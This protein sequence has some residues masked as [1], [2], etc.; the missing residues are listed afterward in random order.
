MRGGD[1]KEAET[2]YRQALALDSRL[3]A[4]WANIGLLQANARRYPEAAKSFAKAHALEPKNPVYILPL[5]QA[6]SQAGQLTGA[7]KTLLEARR[8]WPREE[9]LLSLLATVQMSLER[10][11]AAA[12]TLKQLNA[13]RR[14]NDRQTLGLL[15]TALLAAGRRKEARPYARQMAARFPKD[16]TAHLLV[17]DI[18]AQLQD[19]RE[20]TKAYSRAFTLNP[21]A[22]KAALA[23]GACAE[24][25]GDLALAE[26]LYKRLAQKRFGEPVAR[27]AQ[28]KILLLKKDYV[29][30]QAQL[31]AAFL[32][33]K[34]AGSEPEFLV[35]LGEALLF[36]GRQ[37]DAR[38][39]EYLKAAIAIDP[40]HE[41]ARRSL[42][43]L[44]LRAGR[45]P[46]A[47]VQ[48]RAVLELNPK[49]TPTQRQIAELL[50]LLGKTD[51]AAAAWEALASATPADPEPLRQLAALWV[52]ANRLPEA[53][54]ALRR[55]LK[56]TPEDTEAQLALAEVEEQAGDTAAALR[57]L[58]RLTTTHPTLPAPQWMLACL[59]LRRRQPTQAEKPLVALEAVGEPALRLAR[60]RTEFLPDSSEAWYVYGRLLRRANRPEEAAKAF[61]ESARKGFALSLPNDM[62]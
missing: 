2:L 50:T 11:S 38:A 45:L 13:V 31:E 44:H 37:N 19:W 40:A 43:F 18:S 22:G 5:A 25:A 59:W 10:F 61:A 3:A 60:R 48:L 54:K 24:K 49:D 51:A 33:Q 28:G 16:P 36:Q 27:L 46:D 14:G 47:V 35:P 52:K 7:E 41:R 4:A 20:A 8:L 9:S 34:S 21:R 56:R 15:V 30:A 12:E 58:E 62:P 17:G 55:A 32:A 42:A 1:L 26:T 53:R 57:V 6:Q 39:R 29:H 23:A